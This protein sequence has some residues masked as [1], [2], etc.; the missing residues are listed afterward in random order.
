MDDLKGTGNALDNTL[1]GNA[2]NNVLDG[3]AGADAMSGEAGDDTYFHRQ[4]RGPCRRGCGRGFRHA[5]L[6][7]LLRAAAGTWR[8]W[9]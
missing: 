5:V 3:G 2:G 7:A 1:V 9:F 4:R 6:V 8:G